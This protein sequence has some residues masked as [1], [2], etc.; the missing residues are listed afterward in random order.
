M[1]PPPKGF[2]LT[3]TV[4]LEVEA[5]SRRSVDASVLDRVLAEEPRNASGLTTR[6]PHHDGP[7]G[8]VR[9]HTIQHAV[10]GSYNANHARREYVRSTVHDMVKLAG[11]DVKD[12][13]G[14]MKMAG[15]TRLGDMRIPRARCTSWHTQMLANRSS[16]RLLRSDDLSENRHHR[17]DGRYHE[18]RNSRVASVE[19]SGGVLRCQ[20]TDENAGDQ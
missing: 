13:D 20:K 14:F 9:E 11:Q 6:R 5:F 19:D 3:D 10:S 2:S 7:Y 18:H 17:C 15:T 4:A 12:L 8:L 1:K 16:L